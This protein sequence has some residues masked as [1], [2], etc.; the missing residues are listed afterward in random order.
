MGAI[1]LHSV[2]EAA[3][4]LSFFLSIYVMLQQRLDTVDTIEAKGAKETLGNRERKAGFFR[5]TAVTI[6]CS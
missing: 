4:G 3:L 1:S 5:H 2:S 6:P